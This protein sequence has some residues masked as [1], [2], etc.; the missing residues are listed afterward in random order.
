M[1]EF[2]CSRARVRLSDYNRH[3]R[4][5]HSVHAH[6]GTIY[7]LNTKKSDIFVS[8]KNFLR[9]LLSRVLSYMDAKTDMEKQQ[10]RIRIKDIA[11]LAGVSV[12]TVDRV[13]HSRSGV[14]PASRQ[15]VEE[16]L[17]QLN[18]QPNMYAS[19]LASNRKY[20][21]ACLLP[22]HSEG[23]YWED[24]EKGMSQA[25]SSFSDFHI[26]LNTLYYDQYEFGS[27]VEA[28][29]RL[30]ES[31]P[32]G[33]ILSPTIE[34]ETSHFVCQLQ[35]LGIPY[36]FIDSNIPKLNPLAF[37][38]QHAQKSGYFAA[39]I[40]HMLARESSGIV[41][42]R[43]IYEGRLGSN[44]QLHREEGFYDYMRE[45]APGLK[46]WELN[47]YAKQPG[48]DEKLLDDFFRSHP[49][50]NCGITFNS[51]AYLVGEYMLKHHRKDFHLMGYDLLRRNVECM[52]AGTIDFVIAQQPTMQGYNSIECLCNHLILK[53]KIKPC[54]Y[55]P[56]N[57][58][59][60]DNIDFYF[61][62][63]TY[64]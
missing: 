13:L 59:S 43:Q 50:V 29:N 39:R 22:D 3:V 17:K 54:N 18:Y 64:E 63:H 58:I 44:Q 33:V 5:I 45:H 9:K 26:S 35:R 1:N 10:E 48:Q 37:Y 62:A 25:V 20:A 40:L 32:D 2:S 61:D 49:Q 51:K 6:K 24:V 19:A 60:A 42:F 56:I 36:I 21:F 7:F 47:L 12:G 23:D 16:I 55:M 41:L 11:R 52:K 8:I 27:F 30:L 14:S 31:N 46:M 15:K 28:G 53:K 4:N 57:L 38:G 34:E